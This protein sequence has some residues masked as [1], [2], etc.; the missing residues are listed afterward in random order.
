MAQISYMTED[1]RSVKKALEKAP[2]QI[3][4]MANFH[5]NLYRPLLHNYC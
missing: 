5:D 1:F 2:K 4:V 3:V